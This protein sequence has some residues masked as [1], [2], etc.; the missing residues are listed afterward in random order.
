MESMKQ[1][2][3]GLNVLAIG[4][5]EF[6]AS[7]FA[8]KD[9]VWVNKIARDCN[10]NL[11][12]MGVGG[13]T[14]AWGDDNR[15]GGPAGWIKPSM[16]DYYFQRKEETQYYWGSPSNEFSRVGNPSGNTEDVD[17]ILMIGGNNDY[18]S[19][20]VTPQGKWSE[21]VP[22]TFFGA[23]Q[24]TV[25]AMMK[26]YP[27]AK[28]IF[29]TIWEYENDPDR[30]RW[31]NRGVEYL[32]EQYAADPANENR[33]FF[34]DSGKSEVSGNHMSDPAWRNQYAGD[35]WHLNEKGMQIVADNM[36]PHLWEIMHM[37]TEQ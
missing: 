3:Q 12:N 25:D 5:S 33:F 26:E 31:I 14:I 36:L 7:E 35:Y 1:D 21:K 11:T 18:A 22:N 23:W 15:P 17:Y 24:L 30:V 6:S 13:M 10:W 37:K 32:Y 2:L 9:D 20:E 8:T 16:Y 19:R 4:P 29:L 27:N 34:I 28:F